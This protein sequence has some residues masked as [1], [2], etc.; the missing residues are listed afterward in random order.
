MRVSFGG[1]LLT[2]AVLGQC[3]AAQTKS[4]AATEAAAALSTTSLGNTIASDK[5]ALSLDTER[6]HS[7]EEHEERKRERLF[8]K[9]HSTL[10]TYEQARHRAQ[11]RKHQQQHQRS[12]ASVLRTRRPIAGL[13]P[14]WLRRPLSAIERPL[15]GIERLLSGKG[16]GKASA[17]DIPAGVRQALQRVS[18]LADAGHSEARLLRA[19]TLLYGKYG[20][21]A[22]PAAA[23]ADY[24]VLADQGLGEAHY[25]VGFFHATGLGGAPQQNSLALMHTTAAAIQGHPQA[26]MALAFRHAKGLGVPTS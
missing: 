17:E 1:L 4:E 19:E 7:H 2:W 14:E 5:A 10:Q 11:E 6:Q 16:K 9:A 21:E 23:L 8:Q 25:I 26:A 18:S 12:G 24:R 15:S 20:V 3:L 22:D 13:L